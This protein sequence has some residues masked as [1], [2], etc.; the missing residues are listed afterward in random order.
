M[1]RWGVPAA[2]V[3]AVA[4]ASGCGS[5][6]RPQDVAKTYVGSNAAG[7]CAALTQQLLEQLTGDQ[8]A[9]ARAAC[10]RNVVRFPAPRHVLV[11]RVEGGG[12]DPDAGAGKVV[13]ALV[14]DGHP[15]D[16][17]LVRR[18]ERWLISGLGD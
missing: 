4:L 8:G 9:A 2:L 18:G 14:A 11:S 3:A 13:V 1:V 7:K 10:R 17:Q 15:A 16:V 12:D 5:E 6:V